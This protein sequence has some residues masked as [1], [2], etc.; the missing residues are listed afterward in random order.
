M[1]SRSPNSPSVMT[2]S[3]Y[4][5]D[6][7]LRMAARAPPLSAMPEAPGASFSG[8]TATG[9]QFSVHPPDGCSARST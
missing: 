7:Q 5:K 8:A 2:S 4:M 3:A 1:S 9:L 6:M